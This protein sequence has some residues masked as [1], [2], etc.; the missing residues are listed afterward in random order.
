M[1]DLGIPRRCGIEYAFLSDT[2]IM[3][4]TA[5]GKYFGEHVRQHPVHLMTVTPHSSPI[6]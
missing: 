3:H 2:T 6:P 4:H 1:K 5:Y